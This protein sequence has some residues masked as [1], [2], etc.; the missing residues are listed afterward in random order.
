M[1]PLET[2]LVFVG[3]PL[4][5]TGLT[6]LLV[7]GASGGRAPRY[8]PGRPFEAAP[9]W[10]V[11]ASSEAVP[12]HAPQTAL[13]G[14]VLEGTPGRDEL[15]SHSDATDPAPGQPGAAGRTAALPGAAVH[16]GAPAGSGAAVGSGPKGGARGS[17]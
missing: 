12:E 2:A 4:A 8:R 11:S 5:I 17:W 14:P 6:A 9:V 3:I 16:G 10:Y 13:D 7:Y 1:T 15:G